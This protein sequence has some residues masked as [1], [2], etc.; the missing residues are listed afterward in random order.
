MKT[1]Y[2]I[3]EFVINEMFRPSQHLIVPEPDKRK[4]FEKKLNE[5][6]EEILPILY[7]NNKAYEHVF[8]RLIKIDF[9]FYKW[10]KHPLIDS[11][12]ANCSICRYQKENS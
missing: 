8:N 10:L 12:N 6:P 5:H 4:A 3:E 11:V 1:I 2:N 7:N 9:K